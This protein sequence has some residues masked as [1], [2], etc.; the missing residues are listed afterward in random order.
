MVDGKTVVQS[1]WDTSGQEE[2]DTIRTLVYPNVSTL[3]VKLCC[4]RLGRNGSVHLQQWS[5]YLQ[6]PEFEFHL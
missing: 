5:C 4:N 2:Y 1:I 3:Q 6:R